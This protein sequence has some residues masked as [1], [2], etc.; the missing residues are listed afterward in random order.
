MKKNTPNWDRKK[1]KKNE[2]N[3]LKRNL[4]R[5]KLALQEK[6]F[7]IDERRDKKAMHYA[8]V[9]NKKR[10]LEEIGTSGNDWVQFTG[11]GLTK[12]KQMNAEAQNAIEVEDVKVE[13]EP[14][15]D[16]WTAQKIAAGDETAIEG[17]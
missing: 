15:E 13:V 2:K 9:N 7:R 11:P 14:N 3:E 4:K 1:H 12:K 8:L 17:E 6:E 10:I 16:E 5:R